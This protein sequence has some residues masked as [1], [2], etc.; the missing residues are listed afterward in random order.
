MYEPFEVP[1]SI[2]DMTSADFSKVLF[3][4]V[5]PSYAPGIPVNCAY[6]LTNGI[7]P[8]KKDWIGI[9]KVGWKTTRDYYTF[10]WSPMPDNEK[11]EE[12]QVLFQVY[13][14]PKED[15]EF[16]Q[17]CYVDNQGI[18]RGASTPF[19]FQSISETEICDEGILIVTTQD[20]VEIFEKEKEELSC[21]VAELK[22]CCKELEEK[23]HSVELENSQLTEELKHVRQE[24]GEA[25]ESFT[26]STTEL[27][28]KMAALVEGTAYQSQ[29]NESM[30]KILEENQLKLDN[31]AAE[32]KKLEKEVECLEKKNAAST[33][34]ISWLM[35]E[36]KK[37]QEDIK[38]SDSS[39]K[40]AR[41]KIA[42]LQDKIDSMKSNEEK[43]K[44]EIQNKQQVENELKQTKEEV[45]R[46]KEELSRADKTTVLQ[47]FHAKEE[48]LEQLLKDAGMRESQLQFELRTM[49]DKLKQTEL[50]Y[51]DKEELLGNWKR[52]FQKLE[53]QHSKC[54][55]KIAELTEECQNATSIAALRNIEKEELDVFVKR[56]QTKMSD[57]E[58]Q[59]SRRR[60][61]STTAL[62]PSAG[63]LSSAPIFQ[64]EA[65]SQVP[66][67]DQAAADLRFT[68]PY[69][70]GSLLSE[71]GATA[72]PEEVTR[73][74]PICNE[75]FPGLSE[76]EFDQHV[77]NH[78][79]ECPYCNKFYLENQENEF[80]QHVYSH[81]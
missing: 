46:L 41:E 62:S 75:L 60:S 32:Q 70:P 53:S 51:H 42:H 57:L 61:G 59:V 67:G 48:K 74:C 28:E 2:A 79:R 16:Y 77:Q 27:Q 58:K 36:N 24:L 43:H 50:G 26:V 13:Y 5:Q 45:Q 18:V 9:F 11:Q 55:I 29:Q 31:S 38:K 14:L 81:E 73:E 30:K 33:A 52:K 40:Q 25:K 66:Q 49:R 34:E 54:E 8:N 69:S 80:L 19:R 78:M 7:K 15:G 6:S 63:P 72:K 71:P 39:S 4:N 12:Q 64:F 47:E 68:S 65:A 23:T 21:Q 17:F 20:K 44:C 10:V 22:E 3:S 37:L 56:L 76:V 35:E 1:T